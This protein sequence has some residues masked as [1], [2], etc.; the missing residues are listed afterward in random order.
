MFN[1]RNKSNTA[2]IIG[3]SCIITFYIILIMGWVLNIIALIHLPAPMVFSGKVI[4]R[5]VG[6]CLA[7]L[8][9]IMGW[10]F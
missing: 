8:G 1:R 7:P 6:I 9:S 10:F 2:I 5:I 3:S 4:V